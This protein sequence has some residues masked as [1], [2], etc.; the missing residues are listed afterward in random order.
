MPKGK[1]RDLLTYP[2]V[3]EYTDLKQKDFELKAML[4]MVQLDYLVKREGFDS[5]K[6]WY[7]I[8][9]G[10]EKQ[11]ISIIR[12]LYH[13]PK[14]A[15]LD[16]ATSEISVDIENKIYMMAKNRG[17]TLITIVTQKK[18]FFSYHDYVLRL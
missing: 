6:E 11:R 3:E 2:S 17:I 13:N 1:L 15:I 14:F 8:L 10:G 12:M 5:E 9:S 18:S 16:E 7:E 4:E